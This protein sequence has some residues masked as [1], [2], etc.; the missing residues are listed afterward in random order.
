MSHLCHIYFKK[1]DKN[2]TF[3]SY[4]VH[5]KAF[6]RRIGQDDIY[7]ANVL[8][9]VTEKK[10]TT[11]LVAFAFM[12][13]PIAMLILDENTKLLNIN[14]AFEQLTGYNEIDCLGKPISFFDSSKE[15]TSLSEI[16]LQ[17]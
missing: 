13:S 17:K 11:E 3:C 4:S 5:L 8:W 6:E 15:M 2:L 1:N 14:C 7:S 12:Q 16:C 9:S 10:V